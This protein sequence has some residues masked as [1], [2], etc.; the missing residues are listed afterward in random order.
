MLTSCRKYNSLSREKYGTT[1][2]ETLLK[3]NSFFFSV[4]ML[5]VKHD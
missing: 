1:N 3:E 2:Y 5:V 4:W